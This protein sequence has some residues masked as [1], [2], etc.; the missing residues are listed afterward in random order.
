M[1]TMARG[2]NGTRARAAFALTIAITFA[3]VAMFLLSQSV[4]AATGPKQVRGYVRDVDG[5]FIDGIPITIN[6]RW[7][8][9]NTV[10]ATLTDT[11][12]VDGYYS[13]TFGPSDWDIGDTIEVI[14]T[15]GGDQESNTTLATVLPMQYC[16][17]TFP[18]AIPEFG[19]IIGF[20]VAGG[21]IAVVAVAFL[22][23]KR[24]K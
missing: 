4:E 11:S 3:L 17:V 2:G 20:V 18:Y 16:N 22:F 24:K 10:R 1:R 19:S 15:N 7:A 14:A 6:I 8:S 9:D 21:L 13:Q 5:R 23:V 12:D